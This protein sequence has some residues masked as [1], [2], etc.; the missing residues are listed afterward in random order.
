MV[1]LC[2]LHSAYADIMMMKASMY[3]ATFAKNLFFSSAYR[4][5][6]VPRELVMGE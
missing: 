1:P 5:K 3:H 6:V 2:T 4:T